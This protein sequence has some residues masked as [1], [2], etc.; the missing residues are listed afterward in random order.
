MSERLR[1]GLYYALLWLV[2]LIF[3]A[4]VAWIMLSSFKSR[5]DILAVPPKLIFRAD[6]GQL[7]RAV[8]PAPNSS[9]SCSTA[10]SCRCRRW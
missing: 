1:N 9:T 5:D 2:S 8:Q 6:A 7:R 10:C 4:P 3:F